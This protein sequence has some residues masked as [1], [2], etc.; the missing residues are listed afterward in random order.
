MISGSDAPHSVSG[1]LHARSIA[2]FGG[3]FVTTGVAATSHRRSP[4]GRGWW[5]ATLFIVGSSL[6]ALGAVPP[7][8]NAVG[9]RATALTFF[10][11]SLF[12]TS[13]GFLQYRE[14]VD[15]LPVV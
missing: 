8:A 13:A 1:D 15:G 6:F 3:S 2:Q 7:Y 10:V 9:L 4:R 14:A 11:G 12:F 5:I